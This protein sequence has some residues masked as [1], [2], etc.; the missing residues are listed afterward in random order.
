MLQTRF[1]AMGLTFWLVAFA[2][3]AA[4]TVVFFWGVASISTSAIKVSGNDCGSRYEIEDV[5]K[6]KGS[7]FCAKEVQ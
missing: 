7:L 6:V 4:L 3:N 5:L 1:L 2:I